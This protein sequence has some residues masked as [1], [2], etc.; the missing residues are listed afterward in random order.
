M[1]Y[2][3]DIFFHIRVICV[4]KVLIRMREWKCGKN[5]HLKV[6]MSKDHIMGIENKKDFA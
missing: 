6:Q 5:Q 1:N 4:G 3:N 2:I